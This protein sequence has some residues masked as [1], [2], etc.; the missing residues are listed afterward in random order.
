[1]KVTDRLKQ[2]VFKQLYKELGNAEIIPYNDSIWF[3]DRDRTYWYFELTNTGKLWWRYDYFTTFFKFFSMNDSQ[4]VPLLIEWVEEVLNSKVSTTSKSS[5]AGIT[6]VEEVLNS[7]IPTTRSEP[8]NDARRVEEVL[9]SKVNTA[10]SHDYIYINPAEEVLNSKV[11]T[12][13]GNLRNRW[14]KVEEVLNYK[15]LTTESLYTDI[16][17]PVEEVLNQ[18]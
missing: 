4:F 5:I 16:H 9:N 11:S 12:T 13:N 7:K 3:I 10:V 18:K 2:V 1:M 15:V 8:T 6:V 17:E 14:Q